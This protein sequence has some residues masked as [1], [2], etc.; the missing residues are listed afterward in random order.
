MSNKLV[1]LV[2]GLF[3]GAIITLGVKA[4]VKAEVVYYVNDEGVYAVDDQSYLYAKMPEGTTIPQGSKVYV[5]YSAKDMKTDLGTLQYSGKGWCDPTFKTTSA[6][7]V[8]YTEEGNVQLNRSWGYTATGNEVLIGKAAQVQAQAFANL[9]AMAFKP[10]VAPVCA[11]PVFTAPVVVPC[12][13]PCV[14]PVVAPCAVQAFNACSLPNL[15]PSVKMPW[16]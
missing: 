7:R 11:V 3:V 15:A 4:G 5:D 8:N 9:K 1:K 6:V 12:V 16:E 10:V 13:A 14:A 2:T